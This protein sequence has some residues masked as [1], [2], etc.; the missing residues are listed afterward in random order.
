SASEEF[1][2]HLAAGLPGHR[3]LLVLTTRPGYTAAWLAAPL[4]ETITLEGLGAGDVQGMVRTL[5]AAEEVAEQLFKLLAD[6][7]EGNPLYVEEILRQLQET[8]G[9]AV[10]NGEARLSRADVT[11]PATIHDIIATRI[12]RIAEPLKQTLQGAA[13]VGRRFGIA[14]V[15]RVLQVVP[16]QVA[17]HL[18]DL[19]ALDF[20][21]PSMQ[22]P[23][24]MYSF[25]HALTQDVVYEGVLE[26]RRRQY[27]A[28][29]GLGLEEL[30]AG[31]TD[32]MVEFLAHHF[33]RS[34]DDEKAVDYTLRAADKA[35][36][37]WAN[38]ATLS[39]LEVALKRLEMMPDT[40]PN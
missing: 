6:K 3:L 22:E 10:E 26:R 28:A 7:S 38:A 14:L 5:L 33:G 2:A 30:Y 25:K 31:R 19:H 4:A 20:I 8:D 32:E 27:H 12:D 35:Q 36:Q 21:F 17:G 1:L 29:A 39:H 24:L 9:I 18:R 16:D 34:P 13:V 37:R 15:S 40:T 11:V 23:E